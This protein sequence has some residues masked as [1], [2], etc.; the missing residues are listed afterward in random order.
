MD[1]SGKDLK[2][3]ARMYRDQISVL[4]SQLEEARRLL[5]VVTEADALLVSSTSRQQPGLFPT[6]EIPIS[7]RYGQ[8]SMSEAIK[9]ILRLRPQK[10][11]SAATVIAELKANGFQSSSKNFKRDVYTRLF[12]LEEKGRLKSKKEK[13]VK[14]Y[15]LSQEE[16][17]A[18]KQLPQDTK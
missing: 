18:E 9:D 13:G 5:S 6:A 2:A 8:M 3:L 10:K 15:C 16:G 7:Q 4:E 14:V 1:E 17:N 12:R 11:A